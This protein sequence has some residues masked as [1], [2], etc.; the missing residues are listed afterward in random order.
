MK[1]DK[2]VD[3]SPGHIVLDA[4]PAPL[5]KRGHRPSISAHVYCGQ[6]AGWLKMPIGRDVGLGPG[7]IVLDWDPAP[8]SQKGGT[9]PNFRPMS[10]AA[11][12]LYASGYHMPHGTEVGISLYD[13][14]LDGNPTPLP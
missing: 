12:R 5:P 11:K 1:L 13:I 4:D 3:L 2:E 8:S 10:I 7:G 6:T 9:A 14:V